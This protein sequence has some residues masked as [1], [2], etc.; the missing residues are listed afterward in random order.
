MALA[1]RLAET[2][3]RQIKDK[4]RAITLRLTESNF[5]PATGATT[6]KN[7]DTP[8]VGVF[9]DFEERQIDGSVIKAGDKQVL[10]A[11]R[12][13][14]VVPTT[15][16]KVIDGSE[17]WNVEHVDTLQPGPSPILYKLRLRR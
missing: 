11:A 15:A 3:F 7:T 5:K 16:Y 10:V 12:G 8:T 6:S 4:G 9:S 2:T 17:V 1:E 14:P 13:L